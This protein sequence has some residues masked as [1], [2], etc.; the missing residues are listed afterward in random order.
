M[1]QNPIAFAIE[2]L[3]DLE[4]E[5]ALF[6]ARIDPTEMAGADEHVIISLILYP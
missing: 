1:R 5:A 3:P 6:D 2:E 4:S